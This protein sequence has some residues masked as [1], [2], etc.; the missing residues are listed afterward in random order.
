MDA[1]KSTSVPVPV[2]LAFCE[3]AT[4]IGTNFFIM[5]YISGKVYTDPSLGDLSPASKR[6]IYEEMIRVLVQI[7]SVPINVV[8]FLGSSHHPEKFLERQVKTWTSQYTKSKTDD[9]AEVDALI[10]YCSTEIQL[11]KPEQFGS[12]GWFMEISAWTT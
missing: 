5:K 8:S 7:H 9:I 12:L 4:I 1:L 10:R 11:W 2:M 3:D 6:R